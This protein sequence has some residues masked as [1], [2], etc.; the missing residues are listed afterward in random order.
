[1]YEFN[2]GRG[3]IR[4]FRNQSFFKVDYVRGILIKLAF[5]PAVDSNSRRKGKKKVW[6]G[7]SP[8][9]LSSLSFCSAR[10]GW[11]TKTTE[12]VTDKYAAA[13]LQRLLKFLICQLVSRAMCTRTRA[14]S[15]KGRRTKWGRVVCQRA[16]KGTIVDGGR[17]EVR[18]NAFN[19]KR[20]GKHVDDGE[21]LMMMGCANI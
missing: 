1:M 17:G 20:V 7:F 12:N 3:K 2:A 6:S 11:E 9:S 21:R 16:R 10:H 5:F 4:S 8:L 14:M 19:G 18:L 13:S 15:R